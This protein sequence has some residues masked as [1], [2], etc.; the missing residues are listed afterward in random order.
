MDNFIINYKNS[1]TV[2]LGMFVRL[3]KLPANSRQNLNHFCRLNAL[4]TVGQKTIKTNVIKKWQTHVTRVQFR[5]Q[6][7]SCTTSLR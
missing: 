6:K 5:K 3:M 7:C 4:Q 1:S 2:Q